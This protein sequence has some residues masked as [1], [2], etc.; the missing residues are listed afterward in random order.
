M[1]A[2]LETAEFESHSSTGRLSKGP[3]P[4]ITRALSP[5][6]ERNRGMGAT[7]LPIKNSLTARDAT[8]L[9]RVFQAKLD[10]V[11]RT[12]LRRARILTLNQQKQLRF[13]HPRNL[14]PWRRSTLS[15]GECATDNISDLSLPSRVL[16]AGVNRLT[17]IICGLLK[18]L[19]RKASDQFHRAALPSPSSR[20]TS[21]HKRSPVVGATRNRAIG[22]CPEVLDEE[23]SGPRPQF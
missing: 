9:E 12:S 5:E 17:P 16:S 13:H 23:S 4:I 19:G 14:S 6:R 22:N 1:A 7:S 10:E 18:A 21:H 15:L 3:R 8:D 20:I 2:P 11:S